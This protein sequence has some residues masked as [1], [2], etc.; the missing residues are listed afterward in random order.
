[1]PAWKDGFLRID[2][3]S[4]KD[5]GIPPPPHPLCPVALLS[6]TSE[7]EAGAFVGRALVFFPLSV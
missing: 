7:G 1:M 3:P 5:E 6:A 2:R 4:F